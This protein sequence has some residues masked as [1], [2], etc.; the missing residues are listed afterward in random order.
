MKA[1]K[2]VEVRRRINKCLMEANERAEVRSR[3]NK[4]KG[5]MAKKRGVRSE[6]RF[7]R[8]FKAIDTPFPSWFRM[9]RRATSEEDAMGFDAFVLIDI[10]EIPVQI[11]TSEF[12]AKAYK[13]KRPFGPAIVVVVGSASEKVIRK[14]VIEFLDK[15][16][17]NLL[18]VK[19]FVQ[20]RGI[21]RGKRR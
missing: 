12:A 11:K 18:K 17:K 7:F 2:R 14:T 10:G 9:V 5:R 8:A 13:Q 19:D 6:E 20:R 16:R 21:F 3:I 1:G 4:R 15:R